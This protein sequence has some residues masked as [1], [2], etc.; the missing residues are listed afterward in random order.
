MERI[1]RNQDLSLLDCLQLSDR[2]QIIAR[3]EE[4]RRLTRFQSR[5]QLEGTTKMLGKLRHNL[6][7]SQ[8]IITSDWNTIVALSENLDE[9]LDGLPGL[10]EE[11]A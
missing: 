1:R 9:V 2:T 6:A 8:D 7:Y 4:L 5:R 3:S 11:E 10:R